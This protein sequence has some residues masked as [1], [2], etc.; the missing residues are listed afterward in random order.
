MIYVAALVCLASPAFFC[1]T[2]NSRYTDL[3]R[4]LLAPP[5]SAGHP[6][7]VNVSAH[8]LSSPRSYHQVLCIQ[9]NTQRFSPLIVGDATPLRRHNAL[10]F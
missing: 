7:I 8:H 10:S 9:S 1:R 2:D 3:R 5:F 4:S 6:V